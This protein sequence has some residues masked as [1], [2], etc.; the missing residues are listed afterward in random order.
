MAVTHYS[1]FLPEPRE[2]KTVSFKGRRETREDL[3]KVV[4]VDW[5]KTVRRN[6]GVFA[7]DA[8]CEKLLARG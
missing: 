4:W 6:S 8:G 2:E 7:L 3:R 1:G 5:E